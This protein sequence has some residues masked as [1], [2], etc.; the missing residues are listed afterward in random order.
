MSTLQRLAAIYAR[1]ST[2]EQTKGVITST[3]TQVARCREKAESLGL[4]V[5]PDES[6]LIVEEQHSGADLRWQGTKFM[7]LVRRAEAGDFSDLICLDLDRF[8]RGG[9]DAYGV[10]RGLLT[11]A[12]VRIH[13]VN[14]D[15][16]GEGNPFRGTIE[17][18][19]ADAAQ[20]ERDK[21]RERSM[22][23]RTA[24]AQAG[25]L[26][27]GKTPPFGFVWVEDPTLPLTKKGRIRKVG[28][29]PDPVT[30]PALLHITQ[31]VANGGSIAAAQ[32]WLTA[33]QIRTPS[34]GSLWYASGIR[35]ILHNPTNYG[36]PRSFQTR[37]VERPEGV[38]RSKHLKRRTMQIARPE[39][40]QYPVKAAYVTPIAGLTYNLW[41]RAVEQ[42]AE[43]EA[44]APYHARQ[45]LTER[46]ER[47]LLSGPMIHCAICGHALTLKHARTTQRTRYECAHTCT[48]DE[49]HG[50]IAIETAKLDRLVWETA[51]ACVR[52]PD[53]F[54]ALLAE[55][56]AANDPAQRVASLTRTLAEA[57]RAREKLMRQLERLDAEDDLVADY[58][59]KL[60]T[61]KALRDEL[62]RDLAAAQAAADAEDERRATISRFMRYAASERERL[63][64]Y[65]AL[66]KHQ[67]LRALRTRVI[68]N[69][70]NTLARVSLTFDLRQLPAAVADAFSQPLDEEEAL[71]VNATA[72]RAEHAIDLTQTPSVGVL[73]TSAERA[74]TERLES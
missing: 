17:A 37:V 20:L 43:N 69:R 50:G 8:C 29:A 5:A 59:A 4:S 71:V 7:A 56:D 13:Y 45:P 47:G 38:R 30:A 53:Y 57:E 62:A 48:P 61:N 26:T 15:L 2:E 23:A 33:Q 12:G 9:S 41:R 40:E 74:I 19:Y 39:A 46:V 52:D 54:S 11:E 66:Q 60:R 28:L 72:T 27:A 14:T 51:R 55:S 63:D 34:G 35:R 65:T 64:S 44:Y 25:Y 24:H 73:N 6:G 67:L 21:T 3:A 22:R 32:K 10:Q 18:L 31:H 1:V 70:G 36:E 16:G 49:G 68:V 58:Q 42:L